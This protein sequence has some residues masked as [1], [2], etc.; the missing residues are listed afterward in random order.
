MGEDVAVQLPLVPVALVYAQLRLTA[1]PRTYQ[2]HVIYELLDMRRSA[3]S[4][5]LFQLVAT[6]LQQRRLCR[7][8]HDERRVE[9]G[10]RRRRNG[11]D[12][13][14]RVTSGAQA[15]VQAPRGEVALGGV[16]RGYHADLRLAQ[17]HLLLRQRL[18]VVRQCRQCHQRLALLQTRLVLLGLYASAPPPPPTQLDRRQLQPTGRHERRGLS[19]R[20][21]QLHGGAVAQH[22]LSAPHATP[23]HSLYRAQVRHAVRRRARPRAHRQA[24]AQRRH[25]HGGSGVGGEQAAGLGVAEPE[26]G[27][28]GQ[29]A[30][31]LLQ[32]LPRGLELVQHETEQTQVLEQRAQRGAVGAL[33]LCELE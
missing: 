13:F 28:V 23:L 8:R 15:N 6:L 20:R 25:G 18:L 9:V 10:L 17:R 33:G 1:F 27:V 26:H 22:G 31:R 21:E 11:F 16:Q 5:D 24:V 32:V 30:Q 4:D 14:L 2:S 7:D 12:G 3:L 19:A 29:Q